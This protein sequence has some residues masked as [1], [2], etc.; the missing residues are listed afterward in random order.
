MADLD[1]E[2]AHWLQRHQLDRLLLVLADGQ[3]LWDPEHRRFDPSSSDAAPAVLTQP[4]S[5]PDEP[6]YIDVSGDAPWDP[7]EPVFRD[8]VTSLAAPVHG[9]PKAIE[10]YKDLLT[11]TAAQ[12][13][14]HDDA[15]NRLAALE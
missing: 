4:G 7:G 3:L 14:L 10:I 9:K 15:Q 1:G 5:L 12:S 13:P 2:L 11:K 6:F 8:K